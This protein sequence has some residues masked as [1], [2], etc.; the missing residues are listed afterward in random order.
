MKQ[1]Y[2]WI[3]SNAHKLWHAIQGWMVLGDLN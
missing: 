2:K 1:D 3:G